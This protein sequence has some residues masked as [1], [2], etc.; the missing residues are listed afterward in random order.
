MMV[1]VRDGYDDCLAY[2]DAQIGLLFDE[3]GRRGALDN[4]VVVITADHGEGFG[5]HGLSG[6]GVSLYRPELHVPLLVLSPGGFRKER[7]SPTR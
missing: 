1:S 5:E 4:T 7:P 6:H 3:L 2:L